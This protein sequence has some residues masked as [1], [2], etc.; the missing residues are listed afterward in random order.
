M[1]MPPR[2]SPKTGPDA[3]DR[4]LA[5][6]GPTVAPD[7]LRQLAEDLGQCHA[8]LA[9]VGLGP[10]WQVWRDSSHV[11]ISL[12]GSV[13]DADVQTLAEALNLA[14]H[15]QDAGTA[16]QLLPQLLDLLG[17]LIGRIKARVGQTGQ[18]CR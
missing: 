3:L 1:Q 2:P 12:A 8:D 9:S 7:L 17:L 5:M 13:G 4:L 10:N 15:G 18:P 11:V 16:Q 14:A 6:V